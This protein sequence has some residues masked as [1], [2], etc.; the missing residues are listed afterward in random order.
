MST[1]TTLLE[2]VPHLRAELAAFVALWS[3]PNGG[4]DT[5]HGGFC[6]GLDYNGTRLVGNKYVW[7]NGRGIWVW[8]CC[9]HRAVARAALGEAEAAA[10]EEGHSSAAALREVARRTIAWV[11]R[12]GRDA[13]GGWIVETDASGETVL[14]EAEPRII[15]TSGYGAAFFAE[16]LVEW[17]AALAANS[18]SD[19]GDDAVAEPQRRALA[20]LRDFVALADDETRPGDPGWPAV[21]DGM[22]SLGHHMIALNLCRQLLEVTRVLP[23]EDIV[24]LEALSSRMVNAVMGPFFHPEFGLIC[25]ILDHDYVRRTT[26]R[27]EDLCYL[28]H[29]IE[30]LWM[31]MAE[32]RRRKMK[33]ATT[34]VGDALYRQRRD[35]DALLALA[36]LRFRRHVDV[37]TD[38]V[39]G[40]TLRALH[41][42][43][44]AYFLDADAKVKW[45]HDEVMVGCLLIVE[46]ARD[47]A[48][49]AE[50]LEREEREEEEEEE[51]EEERSA[52]S[53]WWTA[54]REGDVGG[55]DEGGSRSSM[56]GLQSIVQWAMD[57]FEETS[58]YVHA[59]F[60]LRHYGYGGGW[61]VGGDRTMLP[62]P[63]NA[64]P[65][66]SM[67]CKTLPN[68][69]EHYHHPRHLILCLESLAAIERMQTT[70]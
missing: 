60:S 14:R 7:F 53:P 32:S 70:P 44:H 22:R 38:R 65:G 18:T 3:Q 43:T 45:A 37:A 58:R 6:C 63:P 56:R 9:A 62:K 59:N 57:Q 16:G 4:I 23:D 67:G 64:L 51:E 68:R 40:G 15:A 2:Y 12:C 5:E 20:I 19:V 48:W 28:G 17:S 1:H 11:D 24:E 26:D 27:N 49:V 69:M 8:S 10:G 50:E 46:H 55:G 36:A 66:Y 25:E 41:V 31:V 34:T 21:Y 61:R 52:A 33:I 39:Y 47:L 42:R 13:D 54:L 30:T 35:A 29:S